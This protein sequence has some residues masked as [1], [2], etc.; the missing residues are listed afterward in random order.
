[1][2]VR[3]HLAGL[4]AL[5]IAASASL[6]VAQAPAPA[7]G[8][9]GSVA[10]GMWD[11]VSTWK[12][13]S[14]NGAFDSA[15]TGAPSSSRNVF[16]TGGTTVTYQTSSRNCRNLVIQAGGA[17]QSNSAHLAGGK[18]VKING[19]T[20]WVDGIFGKDSTDALSIESL[21]DGTIT[22]GGS[23]VVNIARLRPNS[24]LTGAKADQAFQFR[25]IYFTYDND[26]SEQFMARFRLEDW[27]DHDPSE[28]YDAITWSRSEST[29]PLRSE[30]RMPVRLRPCA[31]AIPVFSQASPATSMKVG[32]R[33]MK[34]T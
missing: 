34:L 11:T 24:A 18:F 30:K 1:M 6:S 28:P 32:A 12:M 3:W 2:N 31:G 5:L 15:A 27:R 17:L 23:G 22:L 26:I 33:S 7:L 9:L 25:R 4:A 13:Y 16:I 20:V 19:P 21:Y 8:D 14:S 29:C 10:S